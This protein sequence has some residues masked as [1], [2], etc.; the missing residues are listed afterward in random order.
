MPIAFQKFVENLSARQ[1]LQQISPLEE[2]FINIKLEWEKFVAGKDDIDTCVVPE[3][4]LASWRSYRLVHM[5][6]ATQEL[7]NFR[8]LRGGDLADLLAVNHEFIDLSRPFLDNL[9]E[10]MKDSGFAIVLFDA[11]GFILD[12]RHDEKYLET[13]QFSRWS[14]GVQWSERIAG[15]NIISFILASK[16]PCQLFGPHHYMQMYHYV[17]ASGAP[18]FN[19][20]GEL[21]GGIAMSSHLYASNDHTLG[22]A[23]AAAHAIVTEYRTQR[24]MAT[25]QAAFARADLAS[26]LQKAVL[27]AIPEALIAIDGK[28][29]ITLMNEQARKKF[30]LEQDEVEGKHLDD[31]YPGRDNAQFLNLVK[32]NTSLSDAEVRIASRTA[33]MDCLLSCMPIIS[34]SGTAI[35]KILIISEIKRIKSLVARMIGAKANFRFEDICGANPRFLSCMEQA[36]SVSRSDSNVLLLGESGTGKDLFA[37][38]IHNASNRRS[39]PYVAINCGAIPRDLVASELFGHV[40][41]SFTGSRRGG[42]SGKFQLADGGSIF[43]DE[44]AEMPLELQT[45][46]L[47]VIEDKTITPIGGA[48]THSVD[49]RIIAATNKDLREEVHRGNFRK[50]L[51]YRINVF[52]IHLIPLS[53]RLD[54]IAPLA[55][56]FIE[57]CSRDMGQRISKVDKKLV[58]AL[59]RYPW[60]GNVRELQNVI[61]RMMNMAPGNEL[62]LDLL[63]LEIQHYRHTP[64]PRKEISSPQ[65]FERHML[66]KMTQMKLSKS[67]MA[68]RMNVTRST[69]Y[70]K[71]EKYNIA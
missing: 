32:S 40:E 71:L 25:S 5:D 11:R 67:E 65:D 49:V 62:T 41:G 24:V 59:T 66:A 52:T 1:A 70:R 4:I 17:T 8:I 34:S 54:D 50:D 29:T 14:P 43:L 69:L 9:Y 39:G 61:E 46:L 60:P 21:I 18:I 64:D 45:A 28:G 16:K 55:R 35:G 36:R 57:K 22:M 27:T 56:H 10:F 33:N 48:R 53:Q 12:A 51:Y 23:V 30:S 58:E 3:E 6:A 13:H 44:I 42:N 26:S 63:P 19:P 31:V 38:A 20:D 15:N 47:R 7:P 37:Q 68:R 2:K